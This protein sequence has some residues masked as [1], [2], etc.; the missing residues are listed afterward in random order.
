MAADITTL[1]QLFFRFHKVLCNFA[2][3]IVNDRNNAED[4]VQDVFLNLWKNR[5]SIDWESPMKGY[6]YK[7][8]YNGALNWLEKNKRVVRYDEKIGEPNAN[9][10][11]LS[12]DADEL[13]QRIEQAINTL[14]P[15]CKAIF[16]LNRHEEMK[17]KQ[18][19][20]H[21]NI[22]IKTVETQMSIAL[23]KLRK[24]LKAYLPKAILPFLA[25]LREFPG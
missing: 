10:V 21:L 12:L 11:E 5:D 2:N 4:I 7:A 1:E 6:L 8:T 13:Q 20:E 19:A 16:V 14:P 18:I 24:E 9:V 22:S 23:D 15:K 3:N 25:M 17:Y